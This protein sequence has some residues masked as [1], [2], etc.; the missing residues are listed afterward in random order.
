MERFRAFYE[1]YLG[2]L[3]DV[4][5]NGD[6]QVRSCFRRNDS[7]PSMFVNLET[8]KYNDFGS[9]FK[10][11][12]YNFYM[13][14]HGATFKAAKK[15]VDEIV[16]GDSF[17][18]KV[19]VPIP[20]ELV[21]TWHN[22]LLKNYNV[23]KYVTEERGISLEVVKQLKLGYDGDRFT[24][25][26]YSKWGYCV[27]VRRYLP[28]SSDG[29]KMINFKE[30]YGTARLFPTENLKKNI[31]FISEG[32]WDMGVLN[33]N[34]FNAVT[35]TAGAG[36]WKQE[37]IDEFKD[38]DVYVVYD[39]DE[40]GKLGATKVASALFGV[41]K[42]VY[43]VI[44]PVEGTKSDKDI[45]DYFVKH[46][47]TPKEFLEFVQAIE[48]WKPSA[49]EEKDTRPIHQI[50]LAEARN[51]KYKSK[52]VQFD[53][54]VVGKDTAP[55]N[56]PQKFTAKCSTV[57]VSEKM[58]AT[59]QIG[60]CGGEKEVH[61][62][63]SPATL[64]MIRLTHAQQQTMIKKRIGVPNGCTSFQIE[65][66]DSTNVEE[67]IVAPNIDEY[68]SWSGESMKYLLQSVFVVGD[69][70]DANKSYR[71][72]GI[73]TP[74]PWQ[75][76]VTFVLTH[77]EPLQDSIST[78]R[79]TPELKETLGIFQTEDV[80]AKFREIHFDFETNVT[81]ILGRDDIDWIGSCISFR[82]FV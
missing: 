80:E 58:C 47:A 1:M 45:T 33:S 70:V 82:T 42:N 17:S 77:S 35:Q 6:V 32:E 59:C 75:Q 18:I 40:A 65:D 51:S 31:V 57:G 64:E 27:N 44:L 53:V 71:M 3:P 79:M 36:T 72:R 30:G 37:W 5:G 39:N 8:G 66:E 11:D 7:N 52:I 26:I 49:K 12:A 9:D 61:F 78:F 56:I 62:P 16:G 50:A 67:L 41:A 15:A 23:L 55:Y 34:G 25:P 68:S 13:A 63:A 10:G 43:I 73:M 19:P 29:D 38:K 46:H 20:R 28:G 2:S 21:E 81:H 69:G 24:F 74:D 60:R 14:H 76:H 22:N 54:M 48:P 4:D